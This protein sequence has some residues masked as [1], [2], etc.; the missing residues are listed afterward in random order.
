MVLHVSVVVFS[1]YLLNIIPPNGYT[2]VHL[3]GSLIEGLFGGCSQFLAIYNFVY[4]VK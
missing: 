1:F 2:I 3:L 4:F